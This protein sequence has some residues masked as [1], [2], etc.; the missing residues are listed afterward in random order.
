MQ[1]KG[2]DLHHGRGTDST[3][4]PAADARGF[5]SAVPERMAEHCTNGSVRMAHSTQ[6]EGLFEGHRSANPFVLTSLPVVVVNVVG[7]PSG[8]ISQKNQRAARARRRI[9]HLPNAQPAAAA[10]SAERIASRWA[11]DRLGKASH[12][13]Q[14]HKHGWD[15]ELGLRQGGVKV[16]RP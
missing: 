9:A 12:D 4:A 6:P 16:D 7:Q 14:L 11:A 3:A 13:D 5:F 8:C 2:E 1:R 10:D 15:V